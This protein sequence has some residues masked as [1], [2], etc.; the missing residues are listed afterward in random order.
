MVTRVVGLVALAACWREA[1]PPT[2]TGSHNSLA[3]PAFT[4][5]PAAFG[6]IDA[7]TPATLAALRRA[8]LGYDVRPVNDDSGLEYHVLAGNEMILYVVPDDD[9]AIFNVHATSAKVAVDG[10]DWRVGARFHG[11]ALLTTC[12]CWGDTPT[13]W[14]TGEHVAVNFARS[15]GELPRGDRKRLRA[16][17]GETITRIVWNPKP[18]GK[19]YVPGA[20]FGGDSYG[21]WDDDQDGGGD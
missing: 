8:F 9:G 4:I 15:C 14:R 17:D 12:E 3:A 5:S 20:D 6:P 21:G 16:L 18:F 1:S 19:G 11:A 13:C 2:G 10:R 7:S